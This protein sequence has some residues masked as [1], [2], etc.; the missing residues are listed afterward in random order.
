MTGWTRLA[1]GLAIHRPSRRETV[2]WPMTTP[3]HMADH[4][5]TKRTQNQSR[6]G[7]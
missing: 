1:I 5:G 7:T 4:G 3:Q 6:E 2:D